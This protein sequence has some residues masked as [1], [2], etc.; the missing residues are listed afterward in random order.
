MSRRLADAARPVATGALFLLALVIG[1]VALLYP[2]LL[3]ALR[4]GT[5]GAPP[6][7]NVPLLSFVL[8]TLC[9]AVLLVELQGQAA[10]AKTVAALGVLVAAYARCASSRWPSPARAASRP[11]SP[12]SSWAVTSSGRASAFCWAP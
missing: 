8:V 5:G 12:P 2:F 3:P 7:V 6:A 1:L 4:P 9:L 11:S 10:G